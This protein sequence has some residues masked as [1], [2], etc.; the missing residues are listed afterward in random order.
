MHRARSAE[1]YGGV[2]AAKLSAD[3]IFD[4]FS[5]L[6]QRIYYYEKA[7]IALTKIYRVV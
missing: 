4:T 1:F 6:F 2:S 7:P 5:I 3:I